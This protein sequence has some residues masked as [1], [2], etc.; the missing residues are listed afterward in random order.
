MRAVAG[1][2]SGNTS[3]Q[4]VRVGEID[5]EITG[6]VADLQ[7]D[8]SSVLQEVQGLPEDHPRYEALFAQLVNAGSALLEYEAQA[9]A[10]QEDPHRQVSKTILTWSALVHVLEGL[11]IALT[12]L[13]G[14]I[15]WGWVALGVFQLLFGLLATGMDAPVQGHRKLRIAAG[16]LAAVTVL[17]PLLVFDVLSGWFWIAAVA[18]WTGSFVL[19][20]DADAAHTRERKE[21]A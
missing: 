7:E 20:T 13:M 21:A 15:G 2:R 9:P 18:G 17:V 4:G 5:H 16:V 12:P 11:L 14:W 3:S 1:K 6:K 19:V 10:K 8:I